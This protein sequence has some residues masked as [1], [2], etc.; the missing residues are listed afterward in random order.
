MRIR[1]FLD[2]LALDYAVVPSQLWVDWLGFM[3]RLNPELHFKY[4]Q[5]FWLTQGPDWAGMGWHVPYNPLITP[6]PPVDESYRQSWSHVPQGGDLCLGLGVVGHTLWQCYREN[7]TGPVIDG[8]VVYT[9]T[10]E[11]SLALHFGNKTGTSV[12]RKNNVI[13]WLIKQKLINYIDLT[14]PAYHCHGQP[15]LAQLISHNHHAVVKQIT[16]DS[17]IHSF[18]ILLD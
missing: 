17:Q 14:D 5:K 13:M 18:Q 6:P 11:P 12:N 10:L 3:L 4:P 15:L 9:K 8:S 1:V 16:K 7:L 2:D